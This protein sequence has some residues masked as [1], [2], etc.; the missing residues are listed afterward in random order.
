MARVLYLSYDGLMEPLGHSQVFQ[1]LRHLARSHEVFL[2]SFE[3][4]ADWKDLSRREATLRLT[5]EAGIRW[6]PLG[7]HAKP[8]ALATAYDIAVGFL[9]SLYLALRHRIQIVH[10]RS[11][12]PSVIALVLKQALGV[13][14]LFD[15]R[16]FWA[17]ERA[18]R[19]GLP[20]NSP[21]YRA[22]KWF[23]E[24]FFTGADLVVSLTHAGARAIG[25]LPYLKGR[26]P[27]VEVI[28]TCTDLERFRCTAPEREGGFTLGYVGSTDTAYLFEPVLR[29]FRMLSEIK[30]DARL[31]VVTRSPQEAVR[32]LLKQCGVRPACVEIKSAAPDQVAAEMG[33][34]HAGIF[35]V[36]P[37]FST[38]AS[39]PTKLGEFLACGVPCLGN[40]GI[41][42]LENILEGEGVGVILREFSPEAEA[43]AVLSL[44]ELSDS[45]QVRDRCVEVARRVF[46]LEQGV[47]TYDRIYNL[48]DQR[49]LK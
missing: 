43:L 30:R 11:Y 41:G 23:E 34:M 47:S 1:Y 37:G 28:P 29:C 27:R 8:S 48:L 18:E 35:F 17:D 49:G 26:P 25:E 5:Q 13:R 38:C 40:A 10:A 46:S 4:P 15:M 14:F 45:A 3:K 2:V 33:R 6:R 12:V 19:A 16:G 39:V 31:L 24:R 9:V 21:L 22:A 44:L 36:K 32:A 20:K 42:D 7:Y